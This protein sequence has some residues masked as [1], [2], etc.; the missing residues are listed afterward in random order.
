VL[1]GY[2]VDAIGVF[3]TVALV[4][5]CKTTSERKAINLNRAVDIVAGRRLAIRAAIREKY[6]KR[7]RTIR[8]IVIAHNVSRISASGRGKKPTD[9]QVWTPYFDA[10]EGLARAIERRALPYVYRE[11]RIKNLARALSVPRCREVFPALRVRLKQKSFLYSFFVPANVLLDV[12][13][14]ARLEAQAVAY[15]RLLKGSRLKEIAEFI[16][17]EETFKNSVVISLPKTAVFKVY[18]KTPIAD[19]GELAFSRIPASVW[20]IDG[21]HRIYGY[22]KAKESFITKPLSVVAVQTSNMLDQA[23]IF[24]DINENQKPVD[25]NLV[26]DLYFRLNPYNYS[27]IVSHLVR[28]LATS[29]SSPLHERIYI[30]G[31][32]TSGRSGYRIYMANV[33]DAI[34]RYGILQAAMRMTQSATLDTLKPERIHAAER[35]VS[36][37]F[38]SFYR[39]LLAICRKMPKPKLT[40]SFVLTNNGVAVFLR[41][42]KETLLWWHSAPNQR[43][44]EKSLR[45]PLRRYFVSADLRNLDRTTSSEGGRDA[46]A[47]AILVE[48]QKEKG[49]SG[50]AEDRLKAANRLVRE[51]EFL[52]ILRRWE[53]SMR[54]ILRKELS[55]STPDWWHLKIPDD[56]RKPAE[57]RAQAKSSDLDQMD[58]LEIMDYMRIIS[59]NWKGHFEWYYQRAGRDRNWLSLQF[60]ELSGLR[61]SVFHFQGAASASEDQTWRL[62]FLT[63]DILGPL[64]RRRAA[65]AVGSQAAIASAASA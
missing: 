10:V 62:R 14:V 21:Q 64:L 40:S 52:K 32:T 20:I 1:G 19:V 54:S 4:F 9:I 33:C 24:V 12:G 25:K 45:R 34:I 3:G 15:Q 46:A 55:R 30:P 17:K 7:I 42:F 37:R 5:E 57:K 60:Q 51:D 2:Q 63:Q 22:A 58:L 13:Y 44:L 48:M 59:H 29:K 47:T 38:R 28:D 18:R 43:L 31:M 56:V 49:L 26:W 16:N 41:V 36:S 8:F 35:R 23:R 27:G 53:K 6:G 11:L 50:F 39:A 61:N 65:A